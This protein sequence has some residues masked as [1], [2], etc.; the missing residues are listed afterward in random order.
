MFDKNIFI[1]QEIADKNSEIM[2][3]Y[4]TL[5]KKLDNLMDYMDIILVMPKMAD[6][7]HHKIAHIAP[8][9][10]DRFRDYN[11]LYGFR[12]KYNTIDGQYI[13]FDNLLQ[14]VDSILDY[15]VDID[16]AISEAKQ[17]A[18]KEDNYDYKK[19][20]N[21]ETVHLRSYIKQ[22]ILL[23]DKVEQYIKVGNTEQDLDFRAED[24]ITGVEQ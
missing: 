10:A 17:L 22:F 9:D 21:E 3:M 23:H 20:L 1:N 12:T 7:V 15:I 8:L 18:E 6:L 24:I 13:E 11:A 14:G 4:F 5:N 16:N 19:F 2:D